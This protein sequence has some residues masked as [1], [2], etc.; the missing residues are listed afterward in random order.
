MRIDEADQNEQ[1]ERTFGV[2]T[3]SGNG[4]IVVT[5]GHDGS[6]RSITLSGEATQEQ[7]EGAEKL[8]RQRLIREAQAIGAARTYAMAAQLKPVKD[9]DR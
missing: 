3:E 8:V 1:D 9:A 2:D 4:Y 5:R 7:I 6:L